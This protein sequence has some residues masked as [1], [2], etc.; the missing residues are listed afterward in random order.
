LGIRQLSSRPP[1]RLN[2]VAKA[3]GTGDLG[4]DRSGFVEQALERKAAAASPLPDVFHAGRAPLNDVVERY[5]C[6]LTAFISEQSFAL[7]RKLAL[8]NGAGERRSF[9]LCGDT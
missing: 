2:A 6:D 5:F 4:K 8:A 1:W 3:N 9:V 7:T